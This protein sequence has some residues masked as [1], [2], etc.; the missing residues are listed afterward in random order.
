MNYRKTNAFFPAFELFFPSF[1][2]VLCFLNSLFHSLW[3]TYFHI[4]LYFSLRS[5]CFYPFPS[6]HRGNIFVCRSSSFL[7]SVSFHSA[8]TGF[9]YRLP[10][11]RQ[12]FLCVSADN[13]LVFPIFHIPYY[14]V[15]YD[16][17]LLLLSFKEAP[18]RKREVF[19]DSFFHRLVPFQEYKR[20]AY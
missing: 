8:L 11:L 10:H 19:H 17:L 3:K 9:S 7:F 5:S 14:G 4:L 15:F 13:P 12:L 1:S 2:T 20:S 16:P 18:Q 6:F